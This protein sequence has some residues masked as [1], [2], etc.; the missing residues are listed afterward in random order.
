MRRMRAEQIRYRFGQNFLSFCGMCCFNL[1]RYGTYQQEMKAHRTSVMHCWTLCSASTS[2]PFP[3]RPSP[4]SLL[5]APCVMEWGKLG[6]SFTVRLTPRPRCRLLFW[7]R[8]KRKFRGCD[9]Q[10]G[11]LS[12][13][14]HFYWKNSKS[15]K[16]VSQG[17]DRAALL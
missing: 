15:D 5:A 12:I 17:C 11:T 14:N 1:I 10:A 13:K 3:T 4:R 2:P 9:K 7:E 6:R 16:P 8:I